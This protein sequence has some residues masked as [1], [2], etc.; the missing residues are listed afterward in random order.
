MVSDLLFLVLAVFLLNT[1]EK[2][3]EEPMEAVM[4]FKGKPLPRFTYSATGTGELRELA[5]NPSKVIIL[6]IWATWCGPCRVEMPE[7]N[8]LQKEYGREVLSVVAVSDETESVV[9][10][11]VKEKGLQLE[12]GSFTSSN[13]LLNS[14]NTRPVSILLVD[15]KVKDIVIGARGHSFFKNWVEENK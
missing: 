2:N 7:L 11:Y 15:K 10:T 3:Y 14:I 4:E 12:T 1:L 13:P 9:S 8:Q 6:N 5:D